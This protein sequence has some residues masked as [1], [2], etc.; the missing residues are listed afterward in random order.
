M[1]AELAENEDPESVELFAEQ[2]DAVNKLLT[3]NRLPKHTE[4]RSLPPLDDR[5]GI[6]GYPYSFLHYLRRAYAHRELKP[7]WVAEPLRESVKP[8]DDATLIEAQRE[9]KS[10]LLSHSDCEG[11]YIPLDFKHVLF[12][13][14][15]G[16]PGE[17]V[18]STHRLRDELVMVAPALGIPLKN[19]LL[20]DKIAAEI[21]Q[22]S[23]S[24][25]GC[26]R[27]RLV[28]LSLF[29]AA[30]LSIEHHAAICFT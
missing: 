10:H 3:N 18:G 9:A 19:G 17:M 7:N 14:G 8:T 25:T 16:V 26:W 27:E 23:E 30:H 4:P 28:W 21:N 6:L 29:E 13:R 12:D 2:L 22:D 11:F 1:L 20:A 15:E 5:C 24:Q